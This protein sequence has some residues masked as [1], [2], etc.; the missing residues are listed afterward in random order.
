MT[1]S[2]CAKLLPT[3]LQR[4]NLDIQNHEGVPSLIGLLQL[5]AMQG[6]RFDVNLKAMPGRVELFAPSTGLEHMLPGRLDNVN[7]GDTE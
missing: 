3:E 4:M 2:E 5:E 1:E 7:L 6:D